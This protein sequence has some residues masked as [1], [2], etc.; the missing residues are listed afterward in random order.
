MFASDSCFKSKKTWIAGLFLFVGGLYSCSGFAREQIVTPTLTTQMVTHGSTVSVTIQYSTANPENALVPGLGVRVHF[1][2]TKLTFNGL[3]NIYQQGSTL[4]DANS[5]GLVGLDAAPV[6]DVNNW[7]NDPATDQMVGLAWVSLG[8]GWPKN[9]IKGPLDLFT[10]QFKVADGFIA[11]TTAVHLVGTG[12]AAGYTFASNNAL[13]IPNGAPFAIL[14]VDQNGAID[15]TDGVLIL[16]RLNNASTIDTGVVLPAGQNNS[17]VIS[18][19]GAAGYAMDVDK[20]GV[21]DAS[22][23]VMIL[24]RLNGAATVIT[25]LK[26]PSGQSNDSVVKAIDSFK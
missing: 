25:G 7:D 19:I 18:T 12:T 5:S 24:R 9:D 2:S 21:I 17:T 3:T 26:L 10:V 22:D 15:A 8:G 14:D 1:D 23:A 20:N 13:F 4:L 6:A 16:R 11:G